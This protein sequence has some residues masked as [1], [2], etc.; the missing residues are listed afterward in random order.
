VRSNR[1]NSKPG[2]HQQKP[3]EKPHGE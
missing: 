2:L 1:G 3:M